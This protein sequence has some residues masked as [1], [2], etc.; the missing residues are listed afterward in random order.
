MT[1]IPEPSESAVIVTVPEAQSVV[2]TFRAELDRAALRGVPPHVTVLYP[3]LPPE[4]IDASTRAALAE[5]VASTAAFD[6]VLARV[7]WFGDTVVWLAPEP[8]EPFRA[9]TQAVH[10]RFPQYPPYGGVHSD[11]IPHLTIGHDAP[12]EHLRAA[13]DAVKGHLP[14]RFRVSSVHLIL[15]SPNPASWQ[16]LAEFALPSP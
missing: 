5:A 8:D 14:I 12:V 13:A 15:G 16:T 4:Q 7:G 9:L 11:S 6:V 1:A 3:F 10:R 2:G